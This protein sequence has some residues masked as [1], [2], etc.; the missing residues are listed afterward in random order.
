M[1]DVEK[2][3]PTLP[4]PAA[5]AATEQ[6]L[7]RSSAE[8]ITALPHQKRL[9]QSPHL[10]PISQQ[11]AIPYNFQAGSHSSLP[12]ARERGKLQRP[13]SLRK[14]ATESALV[15]RKSSK[16][17]KREHDHI[18]EEEIR[19][20]SMPL[21]QKRPAGNSGSMLRRDSKKVKGGLNHRF[22][23]PTS[24]ISLPLEESIHSSMSGSSD[25]RAFRVSA[26]DMFSP[27]PTIRCSVG[28]QYYYGGID[29]SPTSHKSKHESQRD[30]RTASDLH[31]KRTSRIA[32]LAD[33]LDAGAL[34]EILERD[35]RRR[36]KKR[37]AEDERLRRRLERRAE[38]Q[39]SME[40]GPTGTP[41]TPRREA[42]GAIGLG[43]D[44]ELPTPT[45]TPMEDVRPS[46][47]Q[48]PQTLDTTMLAPKPEE[49]SPLPTPLESPIEEPVVSD[50]RAVHYSRGS[51][52]GP[53][54]TRGP[55]NVSEMPEL[56][57]EK[58]AHDTPVESEPVHDATASGSLHAVETTDTAATSKWGPGRRRSSEGKRIGM[59][60][61]FF[62]RG[63]RRSQDRGRT[64]PSASEASFSNTSRESMSRQPLPAHLV[65]TTHTPPIPIKR[66]SSVPRRT[67]SKFREDL[68]EFPLSPPDSRVQSPEVTSGSAIAARRRSQAPA[69]LRVDS[70]SPGEEARTDSPVSPAMPNAGL[71]SQSLA[72]VDSEG[73]W[74]SGKPL[75]RRSNKSYLRSSVGSSSAAKRNEEFN[76]S[77]EELG[78]P[79][80]EYFKRLTPQPDERRRSADMLA[81]KAS[82]TAMAALDV[83]PESDDDEPP[84]PTRK[85]SEEEEL[86]QHTVGRQPTIVHR[87]ARVKS[88]EALLS[89]YQNDK[90]SLEEPS[91]TASEPAEG[92]SPTSESEPVM[93]QRARSVDLGKRHVRHLSAGSAKLLEIQKRA[94]TSSHSQSNPP[95]Q[96]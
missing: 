41:A 32:D 85:S 70:N 23:R 55:S 56:L 22:E 13:Q 66:P 38:K 43:I 61:S 91:G 21:P 27:R 67:M 47:P 57:S 74:L 28:T 36:E 58:I 53:V 79:D 77:Y 25:P 64:T 69:D 9:E 84:P 60:A 4:P 94:S 59:F 40:A 26:L 2:S 33:T 1:R 89:Y 35:K 75:K 10:R 63:K 95:V 39:V 88:T 3:S 45:P 46:T 14:P 82:S 5:P 7:P 6:G 37:K 29:T 48:R 20:M 78:I 76:A 11:H 17:Q 87:Q 54:H 24:N 96:E 18:R 52:S 72:S 83:A 65:A 15:R 16:K 44:K 86:V 34:R 80:D 30:R 90:L 19:A 51:V 92:E 93:V 42:R 49:T 50:A 12:T 8:D 71:M 81:R 68:P 73:S 62:R 31:D